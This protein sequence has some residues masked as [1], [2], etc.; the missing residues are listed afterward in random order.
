M[1]TRNVM[2]A[3]TAALLL[4]SNAI[5]QLQISGNIK[6]DEGEAITGATV[7]VV[8]QNT[9]AITQSDGDFVIANLKNGTYQLK[10]SFF[11][12]ET[13]SKTIVLE[14]NEVINFT[15]NSSFF[16]Q[17]GIDVRAVR[18]NKKTPTTY[19]NISSEDIEKLNYG[20]DLPY[21]LETTPSTVVTSDAGAGIGYTG[22]RIRG[23]DPSSTNVTVDGIPMNDGESQGVFWVNMPDFSSSIESM[24]VQRGV[25]TST[26]GGGAFGA[27]INIAT[28]KLNQKP[29][30][31]IDNSGGSFNTIRNSVS[32]GTGMMNNMFTVDARLSRI[33]SDG[34]IDRASADLKSFFLSG[35]YHGEKSSLRVNVF[36]GKEKTYQAWYGTPESRIDGDE[37]RMIDY[38]NRNG[39][40]DAELNNLLNS[41][42][43]YNAYTYENETD[44]YQQDHYQLHY[45][46]QFNKNWNMKVAAH[47]TRGLGYYEN[48]ETDDDFETYGFTP[49][50][51]NGDSINQMDLIR[52]R[53]LDNHFGGGIFNVNYNNF[54]G[55]EV[56]VGGGLNKYTGDH[57]GEVT[58][59]EYIPADQRGDK[60]YNNSSTKYDGNVYTKAN[61]QWKKFNFFADV[62][63][64]HIDYSFLGID[65]VSG[66]ISELNQ[67]VVYNFFNPKGGLSYKLNTENSF[68]A[69]YAIANREPVRRDFRENTLA[70]RP[71][72]ETLYN[73]EAGY[74][75]VKK[76][77]FL[78]ANVYH[79]LYDNQLIVTG[80][81]NDVGGSTRTNVEDS[82]RL[83]LELE[84]GYQILK[85]LGVTGN[86]SLSQNKIEN[87]VEFIDSY[88]ASFNPLP[89]TEIN[90]GTTDLAFSPSVIAGLSIN[91][92][93][94]KGLRISL[95]N[96]YVG[97]QYL[98]N[99]SNED[100]TLDAYFVSHLDI[101]YSFNALG[102]E[103]ITIGGK[104]NNLFNELYENNGYT[105]SYI[106]GGDRTQENFYYPQA[107]RNFM[108]RLLLKL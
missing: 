65:D 99:T 89:Q 83:G 85:K 4:S 22:V 63:F 31:V 59:A 36:S 16:M 39:L 8:G 14:K 69:S 57:F 64:R 38:A 28:N 106:V 96:K 107:G 26:N 92:A 78:N 43:T 46:Y 81:I 13:M 98:D 11:G 51:V 84:G 74:R 49:I 12:Y 104:V 27:S 9:G 7:F 53:W 52:R 10:A 87:F 35:A 103:E 79:M 3:L 97:K 108:V 54:K 48:Y 1:K 24:Q 21:L 18:A 90:H 30:A 56:V 70:N 82:Y 95:M 105:F 37:Q 32:A 88:D 55:F 20:Q 25:G 33:K 58:W 50:V 76:K 29:Y 44:N 66:E 77:A 42:R 62:Q 102:F 2:K 6:N 17:E 101:S 45:A 91:Y 71:S 5:A 15:M 75:L 94:V 73:L 23:V 80:E 19:T 67:N 93:P 47:Y 34:Y 100:R 68:Y 61:Y 41:G 72:H 40:S 86:L 60:Y